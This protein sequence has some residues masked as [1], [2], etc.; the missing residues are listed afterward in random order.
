MDHVQLAESLKAEATRLGFTLTGIASAVAPTGFSR[1]QE[2]LDAGYAGQMHYLESR[3][4]AYRHPRHVLEGVKS[5]VMLAMN[6]HTLAPNKPTKNQARISRYA[7]GESDYHDLIHGRLKQLIQFHKKLAPEAV[8]RGVSDTAPLLER[9]FAEQSGLGW[10]GKNTM[11]INRKKG[12]YFFLAALLSGLELPV[13]TPHETT[14]CGTCRLCLDACPTDAFVEPYKLDAT[15]CISYLTIELREPIPLELR[16]QIGSW[17]F[18]CDICQDVC[19]WN[20]R[21]PISKEDDFLP[22]DLSNPIALLELFDLDEEAFRSR[23]RKT[24]LWRSKR[25]GILRNAAIVLGNRSPN[26]AAHKVLL[27]AVSDT[28]PLVRGAVAWALEN[29]PAPQTIQALTDQLSQ[30]SD[31]SVLQEIQ[32]TLLKLE[33]G[34]VFK[35]DP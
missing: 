16:P 10:V 15:R 2:W 27:K 14:H 7:W 23:F 8:V 5:V 32:R 31:E 3:R 17:L 30:E 24:P 33:K 25:R 18:G 29:Y 4:E 11:I 20:N 35:S 12:S 9:E 19:P 6:Y 21:S 1:F 34:F 13:D 28:E 22:V 26:E